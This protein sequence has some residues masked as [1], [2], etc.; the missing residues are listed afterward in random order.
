MDS[1]KDHIRIADISRYDFQ[2]SIDRRGLKT[3]SV[4]RK[5]KITTFPI[6]T[7]RIGD[8][9]TWENRTGISIPHSRVWVA[10]L[11]DPGYGYPRFAFIPARKPDPSRDAS[12]FANSLHRNITGA[13][14]SVGRREDGRGDD[15]SFFARMTNDRHAGALLAGTHSSQWIMN[16][17]SSRILAKTKLG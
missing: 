5:R 17:C 2:F 8:L 6:K 1:G 7:A 11:E 9:P 3:A 14:R 15:D 4:C 13:L 16:W 12:P 10:F